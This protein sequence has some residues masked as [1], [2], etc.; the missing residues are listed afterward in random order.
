MSKLFHKDEV[1]WVIKIYLF[2]HPFIV[3]TLASFHVSTIFFLF[4]IL[5]HVL[6]YLM[7]A[8]TDVLSICDL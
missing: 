1:L 3:F 7:I 4:C 8:N 5:Y 2:D 6:D